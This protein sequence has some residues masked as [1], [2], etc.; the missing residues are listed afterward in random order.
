M[1][2]ISKKLDIVPNSVQ[3][4]NMFYLMF[5]FIKK[6]D[7]KSILKREKFKFSIDKAKTKLENKTLHIIR[8]SS[9]SSTV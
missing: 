2:N 3:F 1:F 5:K 8:Q 6:M 9:R 4:S 7:I